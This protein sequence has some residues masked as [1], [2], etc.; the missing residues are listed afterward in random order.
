[1]GIN[2]SGKVIYYGTSIPVPGVELKMGP[3][4]AISASDGR[5]FFFHIA[6]GANTLAALK[7]GF[8]TVKISEN[9]SADKG[10]LIPMT[11]SVLTKKVY[12][13]VK[14]IDSIPLPGIKV[15]MLNDDKTESTLSALTDDNGYYEINAVPHGSRNFKLTDESNPNNCETTTSTVSVDNSD[16]RMNVRMKIGRLIDMLQNGW[17][18]KS[19]DLSAPWNGTSYVLTT[20]GTNPS[21]TNKC[22]RPAYCCPI[23]G[24][25]DNPQVILT[26]R[27][28]GTLSWPGILYYKSPASTQ[29]YMTTNCNTWPDYSVTIYT[30]WTNAITPFTP[31]YISINSSFKGESLK[32]T[33]GLLRWSGAIPLWEIKSIFVSY[34]Y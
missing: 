27:L 30:Y 17:E 10:Y 21:I 12:G 6:P 24:D 31:D 34:Y 20:N 18:F 13:T 19:S 9:L 14:T 23:P 4:S 15:L 32:L 2:V 5:F 8:D 29:F 11:S 26:Q 33:F 28:T 7:T 25:A 22:F 16:T 1:M 3:F